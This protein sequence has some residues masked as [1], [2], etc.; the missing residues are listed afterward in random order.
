M[1]VLVYEY[2]FVTIPK[3]LFANKRMFVFNLSK[4]IKYVKIA[5]H[6]STDVSLKMKISSSG[7]VKAGTLAVLRGMDGKPAYLWGLCLVLTIVRIVTHCHG[8][9]ISHNLKTS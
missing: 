8:N 7:Q 5:I 4:K 9:C 6:L 3:L 2:D 1:Y